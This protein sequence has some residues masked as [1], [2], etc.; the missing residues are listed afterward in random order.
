MELHKNEFEYLQNFA[1]SSCGL[2]V[3]DDKEY[4]FTYR[5]APIIED[6]GYSGYEELCEKLKAGNKEL[7]DKVIT[8]LTTHETFFFRDRHPL[9]FLQKLFC[10]G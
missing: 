3:P 4:L 9:K 8:E 10:H 1:K 5:L 2:V 7:I 6:R